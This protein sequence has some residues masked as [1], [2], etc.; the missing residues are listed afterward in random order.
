MGISMWQILIVLA[1]VLLLFG[2]KKLRGAGSDIG[3]AI[4]GFKK[5]INEPDDTEEKIKAI[6][7]DSAPEFTQTTNVEN[8]STDAKA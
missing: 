8:P 5:G 3:E 1:I 2:T 7:K 6:K 4:R